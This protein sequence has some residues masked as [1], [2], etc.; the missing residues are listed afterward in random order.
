LA[1]DRGVAPG[2]ADVLM[3]HRRQIEVFLRARCRG[4]ANNVDIE[5]LL[6]ELWLRCH[7][8][9]I[10]G[11]D[12]PKSYLFRA[13]HNLVVDRARNATRGRHYEDAWDY[14][15][16]RASG[17]AEPATAERRLLAREKLDEID[18]ALRAVGERAASVFRRYRI[19][20]IQQAAIAAELGISLST[21][22]KDLRKTYEAVIA[23]RELND[24]D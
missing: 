21:V 15:Q 8:V 22:E 17:G 1:T 11:I 13:A 10:D 19:D 4:G 14:T 24:G 9:D 23:V 5:E 6:H 2:L 7:K 18:R 3:L 16:N 20:G 12:D